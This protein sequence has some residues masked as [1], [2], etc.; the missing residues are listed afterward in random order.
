MS[1]FTNVASSPLFEANRLACLLLQYPWSFRN[2]PTGQDRLRRTLD[3]L[4]GLP[5]TV[6][7][8]HSSWD[9]PEFWE[10]LTSRRVSFCAID[11][12]PQRHGLPPLARS[13]ASPAYFRLHGRNAAAWFSPKAGRDER[14]D[15]LYEPSELE[16]L[17]ERMW[18]MALASGE[19]YVIANNH[20]RGQAVANALQLKGLLARLAAGEGTAEKTGEGTAE[21]TGEGT[22]EKTGEGPA[23]KTGKRTAE[24][25]GTGTVRLPASLVA[26]YPQLGAIGPVDPL[27]EPFQ[28][29]LPTL[30]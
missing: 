26:T 23:E 5:L 9:H 6:E 15:Y 28:P 4:A 14:Y 29:T 7:V 27:P 10:L 30:E 21:K 3:A 12:P 2:T 19:L 22:A 13:T 1:S 17:A 18:R 11:Q 24:E 16:D 8:R 25:T 20:Y